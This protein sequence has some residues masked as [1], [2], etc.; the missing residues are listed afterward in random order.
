[1]KKTITID[2]NLEEIKERV[3]N[4]TLDELKGYMKLNPNRIEFDGN[5]VV[6]PDLDQDLDFSGAITQIVDQSVPLYTQEVKDLWYLHG[7][8]FEKAYEDAG[9]GDKGEDNWQ[10]AAIYYYLH[11][12]LREWYEENSPDMA[13][14]IYK[15]LRA[16]KISKNLSKSGENKNLDLPER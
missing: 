12:K 5:E 4:A 6:P 1:M 14:K 15:Q 13:T 16:S 10:S 9:V 7:D 2:D 8:E 11:Q 3:Q